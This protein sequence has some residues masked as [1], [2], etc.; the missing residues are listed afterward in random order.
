MFGLFVIISIASHFVTGINV[1][2]IVEQPSPVVLETSFSS[3]NG[4]KVGSPVTI[5]GELIGEVLKIDDVN[6]KKSEN[7]EKQIV[8][9]SYEEEK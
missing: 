4:L 2:S 1:T 6:P 3:V 8:M 9:C 5:R 7:K